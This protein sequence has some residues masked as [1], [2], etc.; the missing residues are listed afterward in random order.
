MVPSDT[1]DL[2]GL[3]LETVFSTFQGTTHFKVQHV[4]QQVHNNV[5]KASSKHSAHWKGA[6]KQ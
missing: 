3:R 4:L 1:E 5:W 6:D 2:Q